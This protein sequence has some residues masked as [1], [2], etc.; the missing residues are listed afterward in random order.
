MSVAWSDYGKYATDLFTDEAVEIIK[1]HGKDDKHREKEAQEED[2]KK[3]EGSSKPLF[4]YL[5]HLA[6]HSANSYSPLQAPD[7]VVKK[8][9]YIKV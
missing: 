7:D 5:A 2:G 1:K 8:F 6:V 4:L 3:M 9:E